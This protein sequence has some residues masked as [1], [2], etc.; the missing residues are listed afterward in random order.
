ME[1]TRIRGGHHRLLVG[2]INTINM[3]H[4]HHHHLLL[5]A[6]MHRIGI[7]L[8]VT[9]TIIMRPLLCKPTRGGHL[10]PLGRQRK[11]IPRGEV[12]L[13]AVEVQALT[14]GTLDITA[15]LEE[16]A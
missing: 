10:L 4:H 11:D 15:V 2:G 6:A 13:M 9:I 5:G 8:R 1:S 3:D 16:R 14:Q 7:T 12:M